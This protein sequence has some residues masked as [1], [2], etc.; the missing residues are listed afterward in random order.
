MRCERGARRTDGNEK[1][2]KLGR[3]QKKKGEEERDM[4]KKHSKGK[5]KGGMYVEVDGWIVQG[6]Y[7]ESRAE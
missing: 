4:R 5:T 7:R 3:S 2:S 1:C 6:K